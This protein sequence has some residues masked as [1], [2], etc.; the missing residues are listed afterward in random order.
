L[1]NK[2]WTTFLSQTI[3]NPKSLKQMSSGHV[4]KI[5]KQHSSN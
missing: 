5:E 1:Q 4:L 2:D 3:F